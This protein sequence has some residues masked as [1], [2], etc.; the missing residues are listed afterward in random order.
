MI[1]KPRKLHAQCW[2]SCWELID[3]A[4]N[5]TSSSLEYREFDCG[6]FAVGRL[7]M[8]L[9]AA[10]FSRVRKPPFERPARI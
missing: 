10:A 1:Q 9:Y 4:E 2:L 5:C 8:C 6:C 3:D 7:R